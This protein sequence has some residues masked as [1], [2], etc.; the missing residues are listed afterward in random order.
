MPPKLSTEQI[1]SK[2]VEIRDFVR[3]HLPH[4]AARVSVSLKHLF[5]SNDDKTGSYLF[6]HRYEERFSEPQQRY[7]DETFALLAQ[8][9]QSSGVNTRAETD[10]TAASSNAPQRDRSRSVRRRTVSGSVTSSG[11]PQPAAFTR[12]RCGTKR[13]AP[14]SDDVP[15]AELAQPR[16]AFGNVCAINLPPLDASILKEVQKLGRHPLEINICEGKE[17]TPEEQDERAL[18]GKIRNNFSK[19]LSNTVSYLSFLKLE[20]KWIEDV[21]EAAEK[22]HGY[23]RTLTKEKSARLRNCDEDFS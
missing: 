14:T 22:L 17:L 18:A 15:S 8:Y 10:C 9:R 21:V 11:A 6:L 2:L 12:Q 19:L 13:P 5:N 3:G 16:I 1:D 23:K 4:L 20:Y 7:A